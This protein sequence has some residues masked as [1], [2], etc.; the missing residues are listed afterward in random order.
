[1]T[2]DDLNWI[3]SSYSG[4]GGSCVEWAP[5]HVSATGIVPIRDSKCAEGP[6]LIVSAR[7]FAGLVV[8]VKAGDLGTN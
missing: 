6:V 8:G 3:K 5:E 1:M 7:A 4:N 2:T